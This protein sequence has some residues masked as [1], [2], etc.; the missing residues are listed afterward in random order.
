MFFDK[1]KYLCIMQDLIKINVFVLYVDVVKSRSNS[2]VLLLRDLQQELFSELNQIYNEQ[3]IQP[4]RNI[5]SLDE[6]ECIANRF[7]VIIEILIRLSE[8]LFPFELRFVLNEGT[9]EMDGTSKVLG[10]DAFYN[11]NKQVEYIK[12]QRIF[13][14]SEMK[15]K[16]ITYA[17]NSAINLYLLIK[18]DWTKRQNQMIRAIKKIQSQKV[19][20]QQMQVSDQAVERVLKQAQWTKIKFFEEQI[21]KIVYE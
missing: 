2:E 17:I 5:K 13:F 14:I 3:L 16:N 9:I 11:I 19:L 21:R 10:G 15:D 18:Y 4:I 20:A 7:D 6:F 8:E 1:M 12:K